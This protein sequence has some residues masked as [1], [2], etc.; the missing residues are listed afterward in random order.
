MAIAPSLSQ[1]SRP[2][3][4]PHRNITFEIDDSALTGNGF[5]CCDVYPKE[6]TG[7][8]LTLTNTDLLCIK[9]YSDSSTKHRFVVG[10]GQSFGKD[11]IHIVSDEY[12]MVP[13]PG[14]E[15]KYI[16]MLVGMPEYA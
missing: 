1:I 4:A 5:T 10:L 11:Q 14:T 12:N 2:A 3:A 16:G 13:S 7:N 15:H 9:V 6:F 8:T